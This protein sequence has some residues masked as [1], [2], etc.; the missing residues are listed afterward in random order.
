M[1]DGAQKYFS[2]FVLSGDSLIRK[3]DIFMCLLYTFIVCCS[4]NAV[5][6]KRR[7]HGVNQAR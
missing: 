1:G 2:I 3:G 6:S 5:N 7:N 4:G